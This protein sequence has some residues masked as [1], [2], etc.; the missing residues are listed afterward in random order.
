MHVMTTIIIYIYIY[1]GNMVT[2]EPISPEGSVVIRKV[3]L[4]KEI[5]VNLSIWDTA[6]ME[7][8]FHNI[9]DQ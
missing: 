2:V 4:S 6:G 9:P 1:I 8:L 3:A 7:R 5:Y